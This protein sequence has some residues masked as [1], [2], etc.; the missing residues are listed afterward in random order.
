M[1]QKSFG[2]KE[3]IREDEDT[4]SDAKRVVLPL[5]MR[6]EE[7]ARK[8]NPLD[9]SEQVRLMKEAALQ[10]FK[11]HKVNRETEEFV[12]P[13]TWNLRSLKELCTRKIYELLANSKGRK[14][15]LYAVPAD[16]SERIFEM[17]M[18]EGKLTSETIRSFLSSRMQQ[19]SFDEYKLMSTEILREVS[20][21]E[22]VSLSLKNCKLI[23]QSGF[24]YLANMPRLRQL[25]LAECNFSD[26]S[27][28]ALSL[29]TNLMS[30]SLADTKISD[31]GIISVL[32]SLGQLR[33][34]D[35]SRCHISDKIT[36]LINTMTNLQALEVT[37]TMIEKPNFSKCVQM[38][39][40]DVSFTK[41][42]NSAMFYISYLSKLSYLDL[43]GTNVDS[44]AFMHLRKLTN[45]T[46]L[47]LPPRNKV[48]QE[49]VN[50]L[51][52]LPNLTTLDLSS[53]PINDLHFLQG[54]NNLRELS[55]SGTQVNSDA[56]AYLKEKPL[57]HWLSLDNCKHLSDDSILHLKSLHSIE[58]LGL[59]N[60]PLTDEAVK[61]ISELVNLKKL[62]LQRTQITNDCLTF[63]SKLK[64]LTLVDMRWT[65]VDEEGIKKNLSTSILQVRITAPPPPVQQNQE[66]DNN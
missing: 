35:L 1:L 37:G 58:D 10:R 27:V 59:S 22:L 8:R 19:M 29:L 40:L 65:K 26:V 55:L 45:L 5:S 39:F 48:T 34:L 13:P 43:K 21:M 36:P 12:L 20:K 11:K 54:M 25:N 51:K 15:F 23:S 42:N 64:K 16:V 61:S 47:S 3:V 50:W 46:Q 2:E 9:S 63:L 18:K 32:P 30:L 52:H 17:L 53:Y 38:Q 56:L 60:T 44:A 33:F 7:E 24:S 49:A 66:D 62:N 41:L 4:P 28:Q 6:R 14:M 57:L 31:E